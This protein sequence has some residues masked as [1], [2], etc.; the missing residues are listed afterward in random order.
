MASEATERELSAKTRFLKDLK[1]G[2]ADENRN[3]IPE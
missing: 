3:I 2:L 1:T